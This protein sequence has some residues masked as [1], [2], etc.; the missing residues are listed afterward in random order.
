MAKWEGDFGTLAVP[1]IDGMV[2]EPL[3]MPPVRTP[4]P[5]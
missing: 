2:G 1:A 5:V 3:R 4:D